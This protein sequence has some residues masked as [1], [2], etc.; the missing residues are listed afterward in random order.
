MPL[1]ME[2][3]RTVSAIIARCSEQLRNSAAP[4]AEGVTTALW[5][6]L[7]FW[8]WLWLGP[9][10]AAAMR[11]NAD[12][13]IDFYQD[14]G[15]A[16]NYYTGFPIY[17]PHSISIP[18]H[19]RLTSNSMP[20]IE[21]NAHPP[22]FVLLALP[23]ARLNYP[24]AV[25][26]WNV[27]S[28]LALVASLFI[29]AT[30]LNLPLKALPP[31]LAL[32]ALC[33]PLYGNFHLGQLTPILGLLVVMI[34]AL[35]RAG[36]S[37][38]A[39]TFVGIAAA[40]KLFPAYI[41]IYYAARMRIR[42]L[43][44]AVLVFLA[45]NLTA[46]LILGVDAYWDYIRV[47]LPYQSRFRSFGYNIS[48]AGFWHKL[49]D[50][51]GEHDTIAPLWL[52]PALARWGTLLS[53]LAITSVVLKLGNDART[54]ALR[55]VTFA[56][57][58]TAMLLVSPVTWDFS[59]PLLL[60]PLALIAR[61]SMQSRTNWMLAPLILILVIVWTPQILLT[62]LALA[63]HTIIVAPWTF[64]IGAPSLKFYALLGT[65]ALGLAAYRVEKKATIAL[66][67][68]HIG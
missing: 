51:V 14:W 15:S 1:L 4:N 8:G 60:V 34:W 49:F 23:L 66:P 9:I 31:T 20:S 18:R 16:R 22:T 5:L 58:V 68:N 52:C 54:I 39:S 47:V 46:A 17:T 36:H 38:W 28:L 53:D 67:A 57:V 26:A 6:I 11:P 62:K 45:L 10:W 35:E 55:D 64:M 40:I 50:A 19:L 44:A 32:L 3:L 29:V 21:Y 24:D 37:N 33:H 30:E 65:F 56:L 2:A 13:I 48:I 42:P 27:I 12:Q 61:C 41:G 43:L 25:L 63:G 59:L 7:A